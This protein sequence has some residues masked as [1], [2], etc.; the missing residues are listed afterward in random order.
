MG[1]FVIEIKCFPDSMWLYNSPILTKSV[2]IK[3]GT[4]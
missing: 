2:K 4:P 3:G 1:Y